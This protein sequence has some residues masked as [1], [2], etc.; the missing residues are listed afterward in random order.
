MLP[1]AFNR[2]LSHHTRAMNSGA[3][4]LQTI[5]IA[6]GVAIP[7]LLICTGFL[8]LNQSSQPKPTP[9]PP[10]TA[11]EFAEQERLIQHGNIPERLLAYH[12][13]FT[14]TTEAHIPDLI[15]ILQTG[16]T[17]ESRWR[18][19]RVL[20]RFPDEQAAVALS[21]ALWNDKAF[22]VR[23]AAA[24]ALEDMKWSQA[25][26]ML[27]VAMRKD[28][29]IDVRKRAAAAL[30]AVDP[31]M[32]ERVIRAANATERDGTVRLSYRWILESNDHQGTK[33][34]EIA[35]GKIAH[36]HH[37]GT[38]YGIY[39]PEGYG[40]KFKTAKL[41]IAIHGTD[42][43]GDHYLD[44][45][46]ADAD[47]HGLVILA[48]WFDFPTFYNF[49][50]MNIGG[51]GD[52]RNRTDL[53]LLAIVDDLARAMKLDAKRFYVCGQS[54]GGQFV[55]R[56]VLAH[57]DRIL[58]A[59]ACGS[60]S[61]VHPTA[62]IFFPYSTQPNPFAPDLD[63]LDYADLVQA[64]MAVVV[65]TKETEQRLKISHEFMDIVS[66]YAAEQGITCRIEYI[67]VPGGGHSG[68]T[69]FPVA[70]EYMLRELRQ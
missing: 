15:R 38:R 10:L 34:P 50:N 28:P 48:P 49:D 39:V 51:I 60:G 9:K 66:K 33:T 21:S 22:Y 24:Q 57:P 67:P 35:A 12:Q 40:T 55:Q 25:A 26:N 44:L 68:V 7:T 64:P 20:A 2:R 63:S 37:E 4:K 5:A 13:L 16:G 3:G 62:D 19:A 46:K 11:E 32:G 69:N 56:F 23:W 52:G 31:V 53:R 6:A 1:R 14:R 27:E 36:G 29:H 42:G 18:A 43:Y 41:L 61:Y 17:D 45:L 65:G 70:A 58:R 47:R 8:L 30:Y 54:R 59:A